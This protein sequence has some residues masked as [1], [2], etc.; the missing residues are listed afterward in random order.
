MLLAYISLIKHCCLKSGQYQHSKLPKPTW[1]IRILRDSIVG[2]Y[3][4]GDQSQCAISQLRLARESGL[5]LLLEVSA[6]STAPARTSRAKDKG[7]MDSVHH[8][9][10]VREP[11]VGKEE[12]LK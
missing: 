7:R 8:R 3:I 10:M 1:L 11:P 4:L 5:L 12:R 6:I 2:L 9:S